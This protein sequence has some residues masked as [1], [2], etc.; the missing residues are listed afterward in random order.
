MTA[1]QANFNKFLG[2]TS[3][4]VAV[5]VAAPRPT[6][7]SLCSIGFKRDA[8]RPSRVDNEA[9]ACLDEIALDLQKSSDTK[10]ALVGNAGHDEKG[11]IKLASERAINTKTY[12]VKEKGIDPSR[13]NLYTG[14]QD[15]KTVSSTLIPVE[16]TFDTT[17]STPVE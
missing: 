13:I 5:P 14:S 12:L 11:G 6:T 8:R 7:S 16:D 4:T 3:V 17:G 1:H 9:K 10:L 2:T 15:E